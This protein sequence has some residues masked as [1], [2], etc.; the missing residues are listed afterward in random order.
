MYCSSCFPESIESRTTSGASWNRPDDY[1]KGLIPTPEGRIGGK[2]ALSSYYQYADAL[3]GALTEDFGPDDL[4]MVVSDHG[5]EAGEA[6]LRLSG[7][8]ESEKALH[9]IVFA[10]GPGIA[11]GSKAK[12]VSVTDITPTLLTWLGLPMALDMD[13]SPARFLE[14]PQRPPIETYDTIEI[15]YI[16]PEETPSG[17]EDDIVEQLKSLGY[18]DAE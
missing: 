13:G 1:P 7:I 4:V 18:I 3:I 14:T 12:G 15:E 9:G 8:H 11:P 2:L 10:R 6:L 17:V 16:N 5:F